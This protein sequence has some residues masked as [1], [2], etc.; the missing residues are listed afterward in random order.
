MAGPLAPRTERNKE[1][2]RVSLTTSHHLRAFAR[3]ACAAFVALSVSGA[4]Q[5]AAA[6]APKPPHR[7]GCRAKGG[8]HVCECVVCQRLALAAQASDETLPPCHREAARA[9]LTKQERRPGRDAAPCMRG[10]C[11]RDDGHPMT[12]GG[13]DPWVVPARAARGPSVRAEPHL[14]RSAPERWR[15]LAPEPPPPRRA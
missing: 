3:A 14:A 5:L 1:F 2:G 15:D 7:C 10:V 11:G 12:F 8:K 4:P 9:S 13:G 6:H